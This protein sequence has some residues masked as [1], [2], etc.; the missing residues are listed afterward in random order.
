MVCL[1]Q[2][3]E[4][5]E[6]WTTSSEEEQEGIWCER[7]NWRRREFAVGRRTARCQVLPSQSKL[8]SLALF[9]VSSSPSK[10]ANSLL[11][12]DKKTSINGIIYPSLFSAHVH[13]L[14]FILFPICSRFLPAIC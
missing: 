7:E 4:R 12:L 3:G 9:L 5:R 11:L 1:K 10:A 13:R 6:N 2:T 8:P 14:R